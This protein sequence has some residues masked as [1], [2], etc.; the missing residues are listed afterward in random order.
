MPVPWP[1][2]AELKLYTGGCHCKKVR[3]EFEHPD[4]YTMPTINC[5]CSIC[6]ERGYLNVSVFRTGSKFKITQGADNLSSYHF[7]SEKIGHRFCSTCGS[8]ISPD[9]ASFFGCIA[10]NTRTIDDIDISK[11]TLQAV[12][13]KARPE[14]TGKA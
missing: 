12:D 2:N 13:G 3:F 7:G 6:E 8:S 9:A 5:N 11:L 10:V 1:E 14:P 4:I